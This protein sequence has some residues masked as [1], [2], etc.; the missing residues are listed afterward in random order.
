M[1]QWLYS[2]LPS[3][4]HVET[5]NNLIINWQINEKSINQSTPPI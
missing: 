2:L 4:Y 3:K 1:A 5:Y